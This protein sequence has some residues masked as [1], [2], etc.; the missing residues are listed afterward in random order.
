MAAVERYSSSLPSVTHDTWDWYMIPPGVRKLCMISW[1]MKGP[2]RSK[3][4]R[5]SDLGKELSSYRS[6]LLLL[7]VAGESHGV[8]R[9]PPRGPSIFLHEER[10]NVE[11]Y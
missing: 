2:I 10:E 9:N 7:S 6:C 8:S 5:K 4:T 3:L 1:S 11:V